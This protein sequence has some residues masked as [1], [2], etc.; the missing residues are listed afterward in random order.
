[1]LPQLTDKFSITAAGLGALS[2]FFYYPY[3]LMQIPVGIITDKFGPKKVM[4]FASFFTG[5]ACIVFA[6]ANSL[7]LAIIARMMMGFCGAFAFVGTL[8]LAINFFTPSIFATLTGITQ[9]MGMLGAAIGGAP[10]SIY[11]NKVGIELAML[12]FAFLFFAIGVLMLWISKH[13]KQKDLKNHAPPPSSM[14]FGIKQ[15]IRNKSLWANCLFIG[16]LYGPTTVFAEMWGVSFTE[17]FRAISHT[18]AAF[19]TS[20]IFIGMVFGCP[21]FG[22]VHRYWDALYLMR[23][24]ALSC[25]IL[26]VV[27]LYV[28]GLSNFELQVTYFCYGICNA[29]II[30]AYNRA[31][32]TVP[33]QH[34]GI[35]LGLTN[36][37]SVLLGAISIQV[38]GVLIHLIS[39][40]PMQQL[41]N[42]STDIYQK[43]FIIIPILFSICLAV[44]FK[45]QS[46]SK[47]STN[48]ISLD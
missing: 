47:R 5:I 33:R 42:Y 25:L 14:T 21:L 23:L 19:V 17:S 32:L 15:I 1:M 46:I 9:A 34:S 35:A 37:S 44:S 27:I 11:V 39:T 18:D 7:T 6:L 12:S 41:H 13:P 40:P 24:S 28:P 48:I 20:L 8:R 36:M 45:M 16:C 29:G 22:F 30:P 2:A 43:I 38:V 10:M 3:I 26:M 4:I 31:A